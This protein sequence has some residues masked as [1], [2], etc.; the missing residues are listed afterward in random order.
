[1]RLIGEKSYVVETSNV[2][3]F[4]LPMQPKPLD[5]VVDG[6]FFYFGTLGEDVYIECNDDGVWQVGAFHSSDNTHSSCI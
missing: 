2:R 4:G 1:M 3:L 5:L 6:N